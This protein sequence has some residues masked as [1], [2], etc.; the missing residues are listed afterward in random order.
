MN[1]EETKADSETNEASTD[2]EALQK[3]PVKT[4][5]QAATSNKVSTIKSSVFSRIGKRFSQWLLIEAPADQD[6]DNNGLAKARTNMATTR[7]LMAADR[8]LMA[9]MRT[10][11]S[12][13]SFGFTIYKILQGLQ[14]SGD[15]LKHAYDPQTVG[16]FLIG[17][18]TISMILGV[19]EY[20]STIKELR[21]LKAIPWRRPS[22]VISLIMAASG[23]LVFVSV[24]THI[25]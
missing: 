21:L 19:V 16:L 23:S 17:L 4:H 9:W 6:M 11:L 18:G 24:V 10:A 15:T 7:T 8:T 1:A 14:S 13:I 22:F 2:S 12:M 20:I 25:I 3:E 5:K